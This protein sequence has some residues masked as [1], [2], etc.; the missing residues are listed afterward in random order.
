MLSNLPNYAWFSL[1]GL[2]HLLMSSCSPFIALMS[3]SSFMHVSRNVISI[4]GSIYNFGLSFLSEVE[5]LAKLFLASMKVSLARSK[6]NSAS[7]AGALRTQL[8]SSSYFPLSSPITIPLWSTMFTFG[9]SSR[10]SDLI[11]CRFWVGGGSSALC[12]VS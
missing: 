6:S 4:D 2:A 12:H 1:G 3:H 5:A 10:S 8:L 9:S 11:I 7:F